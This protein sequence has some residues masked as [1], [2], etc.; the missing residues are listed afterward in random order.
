MNEAGNDNFLG[1]AGWAIDG[2]AREPAGG[3]FVMID[4]K[5]FP[6]VYGLQ[7]QVNVDGHSY[8]DCGFS[9]L[10]PIDEIGP[11]SH[12]V[13]IAVLTRDGT[14]YYQ[15]APPRTFTTSQFFP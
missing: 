12:Q 2:A 14:G 6:A 5:L 10:I 11:G 4:E 9:R 1:V 8:T 3:V 15:P 7:S 13:S